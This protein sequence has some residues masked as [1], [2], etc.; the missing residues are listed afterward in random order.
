VTGNKG[1]AT[2]TYMVCET[3]GSTACSDPVA[4]TY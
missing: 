3:G 1:G 2:Y 4:V